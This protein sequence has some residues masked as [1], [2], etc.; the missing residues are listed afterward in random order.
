MTREVGP[1]AVVGFRR[2]A[3]PGKWFAKEAV[4]HAGFDPRFR[5]AHYRALALGGAAPRRGEDV[6]L[7]YRTP[8]PRR[9]RPVRPIPQRNRVLGGRV[10]R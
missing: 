9:H 10:N 4:F 5:D 6:C 7:D 8:P 2:D 1:G 3:G